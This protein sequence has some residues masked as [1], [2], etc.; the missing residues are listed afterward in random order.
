M[1]LRIYTH[2]KLN[3]ITARGQQLEFDDKMMYANWILVLI[4]HKFIAIFNVGIQKGSRLKVYDIKL[5][6][7][8]YNED[9]HVV[10]ADSVW[11]DYVH[12]SS[13]TK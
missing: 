6:Q 5:H 12:K 10:I 9:S 13:S 8:N 3:A 1:L 11:K 2:D 7:Q 4:L